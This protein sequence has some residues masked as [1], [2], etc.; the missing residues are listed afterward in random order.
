MPEQ[1]VE[2]WV[3]VQAGEVRD[4]HSAEVIHCHQNVLCIGLAS[5]VVG[6]A[7]DH[8][9]TQPLGAIG[10]D[11]GVRLPRHGLDGL[12][13]LQLSAVA[14][15]EEQVARRAVAHYELAVR[16]EVQ[17]LNLPAVA[18]ALRAADVFPGVVH[19]HGA[20]FGRESELVA[21]G[22]E[23]AV[24]DERLGIARFVQQGEVLLAQRNE[25][26]LL[27]LLFAR[28]AGSETNDNDGPVFGIG[29]AVPHG[30][31]QGHP[32][33]PPLLRIEHSHCAIVSHCAEQLRLQRVR[34]QAAEVV[35]EVPSYNR[36]AIV[37]VPPIRGVHLEHLAGF[38]AHQDLGGE[39]VA[40]DGGDAALDRAHRGCIE[41][42]AKLQLRI[43]NEDL[44]LTTCSDQ[45]IFFLVVV[46]VDHMTSIDST[47]VSFDTVDQVAALPNIEH[48]SLRAREHC[49][50]DDSDAPQSLWPNR[51]AELPLVPLELAGSLGL[52]P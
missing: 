10:V 14:V 38:E 48:A 40:A 43:P 31:E 2:G 16:G 26:P 11:T 44:A 3:L 1:L 35:V 4:P 23:F 37:H 47:C 19:V 20:V 34:R 18:P 33:L 30:V 7:V 39:D 27:P 24:R 6:S 12:G 45:S 46:M 42:G 21:T 15:P 13:R 9:T 36:S 41:S 29:A 49:L 22:S 8:C 17:V 32:Q 51:R 52:P 50:A 5:A 25:G 28:Y